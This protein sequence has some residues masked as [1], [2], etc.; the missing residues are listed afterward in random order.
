MTASQL[1][2]TFILEALMSYQRFKEKQPAP[3]TQRA[4][5]AAAAA[6]AVSPT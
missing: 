2:H 5:A 4:A 6:A 1:L 3:S